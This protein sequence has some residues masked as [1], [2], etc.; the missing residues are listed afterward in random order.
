MLP[1]F[2][3]RG[4]FVGASFTVLTDP[5]YEKSWWG[6]G[7]VRIAPDGDGDAH[8]LVGTGAE[9]YIG[10]AWRQGA[11]VNRYQG[12]PVA[13]EGA[14]RWTYYRFHVPDPIFFARDIQ[15]EFQQIG[16]WPKKEVIRLQRQGAPLVPVTID[17]GSRTNFQQLLKGEKPVPLTTPGR[18]EGWTNFY[19][20]DDV[21]SVA[22]FY[23][24]RPRRTAYPGS[25]RQARGWRASASPARR[26]RA[27]STPIRR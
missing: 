25:R 11:F 16:G 22:Y 20:S 26:S 3:G 17:P 12:A 14:G 6:E 9:D 19:R 13:D 2:T 8:L 4:R 10:T 23:F 27:A 5:V 24:D 7:E 18:P 1:R 15:V 21:A